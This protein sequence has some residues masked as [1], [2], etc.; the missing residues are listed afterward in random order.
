MNNAAEGSK[1]LLLYVD[2]E[3]VNHLI[4][5]ITLKKDFVILNANSGVEGLE[6]IKEQEKLE[7][8]ISDMRMPLMDGLEF[9]KKAKELRDDIKYFLLT[10][11]EKTVEIQKALDDNL[12]LR[13]FQKPFNLEEFKKVLEEI[14][15]K[16][17]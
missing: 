1:P 4:F 16:E 12:I 13:Y 6:K 5:N 17:D 2:D 10:G 3:E 14:E 7:I 9:V 15:S 8:V 11:F